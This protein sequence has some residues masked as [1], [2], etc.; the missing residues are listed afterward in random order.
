[1]FKVSKDTRRMSW[2]Y[3]TP[4]PIVSIVDFEKINICREITLNSNEAD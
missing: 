1:M 2:T 4:F 3:F